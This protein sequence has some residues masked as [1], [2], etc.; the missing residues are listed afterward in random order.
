MFVVSRECQQELKDLAGD[1]DD[2]S[3]ESAATGPGR[4]SPEVVVHGISSATWEDEDSAFNEMV[5]RQTSSVATAL[6]SAFSEPA[7]QPIAEPTA[8][9]VPEPAGKPEMKEID[10]SKTMSVISRH[11]S[12]NVDPPPIIDGRTVSVVSR[13]RSGN[14]KSHDSISE[15]EDV[16]RL[17]VLDESRCEDIIL[18]PSFRNTLG[19]PSEEKRDSGGSSPQ[20]ILSPPSMIEPTVYTSEEKKLVKQP[21][22]AAEE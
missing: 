16:Y 18:P 12:D 19:T 6:F 1:T 13:T 10:V 20:S 14:E 5:P 22:A 8:R 4:H 21:T 17:S 7:G 11:R 15:A 2:S 9:P 3:E